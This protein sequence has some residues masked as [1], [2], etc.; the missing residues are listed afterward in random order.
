MSLRYLPLLALA[1]GLVASAAQAAPAPGAHAKPGGAC[2]WSR[3]IT[4]W[5][6]VGERQ[7]NLE[8]LHRDVYRLDLG[9]NCPSLHFAHQSLML[10]AAGGGPVCAS[11][12][13]DVIVPGQ[14]IR[15]P[16]VSITKLTPDQVKALPKNERP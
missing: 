15:C 8:V 14:G 4:N 6:D 12:L 7:V 10:D 3:D 5:R 16:V 9:V 13:P 1:A 11:S 2:F